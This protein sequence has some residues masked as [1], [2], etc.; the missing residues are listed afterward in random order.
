MGSDCEKETSGEGA[1]AAEPDGI[2]T[3]KKE[4]RTALS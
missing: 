4:Q 2:F 1:V 3:F